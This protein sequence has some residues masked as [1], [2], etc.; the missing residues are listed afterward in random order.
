VNGKSYYVKDATVEM[1]AIELFREEGAYG[2]SWQQL[3]E[4]TR[5]EYREMARGNKPFAVG[6]DR[7]GVKGKPSEDGFD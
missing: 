7:R 2:S 1:L 5:N 4:S 6:P 3:A